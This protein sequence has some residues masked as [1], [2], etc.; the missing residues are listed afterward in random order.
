MTIDPV[1][2]TVIEKGLQQVCSEMDLVH[3]KTS[4]SPRSGFRSSS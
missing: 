2:L 3:E 1:T 4:F